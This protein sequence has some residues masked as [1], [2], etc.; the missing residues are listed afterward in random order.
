MSLRKITLRTLLALLV[1]SHSV[2][3]P[4]DANAAGAIN[5]VRPH[6]VTS[7]EYLQGLAANGQW[8][9]GTIAFGDIVGLFTNP[10]TW[11]STQTFSASPIF[12][13]LTGYLKGNGASALS[14]NPTV[15]LADITA[16]AAHTIIGNNTSGVAAPTALTDAQVAAELPPCVGDSGTGGVK[17]LVPA[18]G[19][20][21]GPANRVLKA[22]CTWGNVAPSFAN[23]NANT[24]FAGPASGAAAAPSFRALTNKDIPWGVWLPCAYFGAPLASPVATITSTTA[25]TS[26]CAPSIP[27]GYVA[28]F[29][30]ELLGLTPVADN[31]YFVLQVIVGGSAQTANYQYELFVSRDTGAGRTGSSAAA[32][33]VFTGPYQR[34]PGDGG[35]Y[36]TVTI[37]NP[38]D[39]GYYKTIRWETGAATEY[40]LHPATTIGTGIWKG[41]TGAI[42]G[43]NIYAASGNL[44]GYVLVYVRLRPAP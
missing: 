32:G 33:I 5:R 37:T 11:T 38:A 14:A 10:H 42:A 30:L 24:V 6:A 26:T 27:G 12:V 15:P 17:G 8:L 34:T 3:W 7:G 40:L 1:V 4:M 25:F 36:G 39:T 22:D 44:W 16:I 28:D 41:G 13:P 35:L 31:N 43:F 20:G 9:T 2:L 18:P 19:A 29:K 23:Q 21:D